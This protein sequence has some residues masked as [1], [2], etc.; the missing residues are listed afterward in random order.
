MPSVREQKAAHHLSLICKQVRLQGVQPLHTL[1]F[2][3]ISRLA[4]DEIDFALCKTCGD[5]GLFQLL[6][7]GPE[8]DAGE[9]NAPPVMALAF[10]D[11]D[12]Q[13]VVDAGR[14]GKCLVNP[15]GKPLLAETDLNPLRLAQ[16][17]Q[18]RICGLTKL[19]QCLGQLL[20][21]K[22][23]GGGQNGI[24]DLQLDGLILRRIGIGNDVEPN[25]FFG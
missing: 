25:Q 9:D 24:T 19:W 3:G 8:A 10:A 12:P 23:L 20:P 6:R 17:L 16:A 18:A 13:S 14:Q 7:G 4:G 15:G 5:G 21:V 11:G 1:E 2:Q 22:P